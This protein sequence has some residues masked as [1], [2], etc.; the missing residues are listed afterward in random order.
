MAEHGIE[1]HLDLTGSASSV[2][3]IFVDDAGERAI[4]MA[5][6]ATAE[7]TADHIRKDHADYNI[8]KLQA[9]A[10]L[11]ELHEKEGWPLRDP[12]DQL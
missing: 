6:G 11:L 8:E 10:G 5:R 3:E 7:T 2:A 1:T 12:P 4:Y 9:V